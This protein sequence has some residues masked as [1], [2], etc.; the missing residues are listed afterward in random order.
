M[1]NVNLVGLTGINLYK[2]PRKASFIGEAI[3]FF[4]VNVKMKNVYFKLD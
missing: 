4:I 2:I 3:Y 1:E